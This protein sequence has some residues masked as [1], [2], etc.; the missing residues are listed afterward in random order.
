MASYRELLGDVIASLP[1]VLTTASFPVM[2]E[3][4]DRTTIRISGT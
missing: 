4:M 3:V 1:G 2:E